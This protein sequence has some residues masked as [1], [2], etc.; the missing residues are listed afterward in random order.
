MTLQDNQLDSVSRRIKAILTVFGVFAAVAAIVA[1]VAWQSP[2]RDYVNLAQPLDLLEERDPDFIGALIGSGGIVLGSFLFLPMLAL[3]AANDVVFG[4]LWGSAFSFIGIFVAGSIHFAL[5]R[6]LHQQ[7]VN[8]IRAPIIVVLRRKFSKAG[9]WPIAILRI[10]PVAPFVIINMAAGALKIRLIDFTA[11]NLMGSAVPIIAIAI[12]DY[13]VG[14]I[15]KTPNLKSF[16]LSV[17]I[18]GTVILLIARARK[19][20][21]RNSKNQP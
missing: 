10:L 14:Q 9:P 17:L 2:L 21:Q 8:K 18:I 15:A 20:I 13:Q 12:F 3:F 16:I 19:L 1:L 11:G 7:I 4:P 5:G 6:V